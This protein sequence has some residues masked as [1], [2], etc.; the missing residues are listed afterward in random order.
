V[1]RALRGD[2]THLRHRPTGD[3]G[4]VYRDSTVE[5]VWVRKRGEIVDPRWFSSTDLDILTV[6][7]G[8]L[9]VEFADT[10]ERPRV[11]KVGDVLVLPPKTKCRAYRWPRTA[12]R[13]TIFIATYPVRRGRSSGKGKLRVG[14]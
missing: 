3:V 9:R 13:A 5:V 1:I 6:V 11:L 14:T 7:Q 2:G 10:R 12:R 4:T 8:R